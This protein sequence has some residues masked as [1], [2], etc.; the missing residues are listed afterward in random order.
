MKWPIAETVEV[1]ITSTG[2]VHLVDHRGVP[3]CRS[4]RRWVVLEVTSRSLADKRCCATCDRI[5]GRWS[6]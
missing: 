6:A 1:G 3:F 5:V 2:A 4:P